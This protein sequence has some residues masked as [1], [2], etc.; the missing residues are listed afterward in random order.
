MSRS[1]H[2]LRHWVAELRSGP[3]E[4]GIPRTSYVR[5]CAAIEPEPTD[6]STHV[7]GLEKRY[8]HLLRELPLGGADA[9]RQRPDGQLALTATLM[10]AAPWLERPIQLIDRQLRFQLWAGRPWVRFK[11]MLLVGPPG[12]GKSHLAR[13]IAEQCGVGHASL[14]LA[15]VSDNRTL[16]GTARGWTNA[17]PC[18]PAITINRTRSANPI[19]ALEEVDKAGGSSRNGNSLSTL[20]TMIEASTARRFFDKCLM[21]PVDLS[22]VNWIM[23]A[24][25]ADRLPGPLRSRLSIVEVTGP[26]PEHFDQLLAGLVRSLAAQLELA[27]AMLPTLE[28]EM[29][30]LLRTRFLRHRSVRRTVAELE[31]VMATAIRFNP[32]RLH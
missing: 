32:R 29:V 4:F 9:M 1:D 14:D 17:Q 19:I 16:E 31:A 28:P 5:V 24:Y 23:T 3:L 21:A 12:C 27:P 13:V 18:F 11:P 2:R 7:V 15:G 22:H 10:E 30:D 6:G 25:R 8:R 26:G 20:L